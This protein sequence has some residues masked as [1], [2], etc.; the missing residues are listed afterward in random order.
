MD[1]R[2]LTEYRKVLD[3][4]MAVGDPIDVG[5]LDAIAVEAIGPHRPG[6]P[7]D[8][9]GAWTVDELCRWYAEDRIRRLRRR[10]TGAPPK[11]PSPPT[12]P[13]TP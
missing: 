3:L 7:T 13:R 4:A 11:R 10:A 6:A 2:A 1:K 5:A 9:D 12:S 8:D